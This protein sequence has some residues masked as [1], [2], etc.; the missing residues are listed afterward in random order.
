MAK[1]SNKELLT[2]AQNEETTPEQLNKIWVES[3][4]VKV[5]KAV[6][7][8]PNADAITLRYAARL[9]IEEVL[10]NPGFQVLKLFDDDEWIRKIGEIYDNPE[11]W[12]TVYYYA[13]RTEQLEP[14][15]RAALLSSSL[16]YV[17]LN[18]IIE[19][20]PV[21][22]LKRAFK[23]E[24]T[25]AK[26]RKLLKGEGGNFSL[27]AMFK[28]YNS[29]L[30]AEDE[31]YECLKYISFVGSLSCRKSVYTKTIKLLFKS[32]DEQKYGADKAM[33]M[34]L[35]ASRSTCIRWIQYMFEH[36]HLKII[37]SALLT[38]KR[39][40]KKASSTSRT[41]IQMLG[42]MI[43][44][45]LWDPLNF[46]QRKNSFES[47]YKSMCKLGLDTHPWGDTKF[48]WGAIHITNEMC[49]ELLKEDIRV[50]AFFV[51]NKCLGTWFSVQ[52]SSSKFQLVEEVNDW[53]YK[54]GGF[55]NLLYNSVSLRK[56]VTIS[57]DVIIAR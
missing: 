55:E 8:N 17:Q 39:L 53:M 10:E 12:S 15:A 4:S 23:Y 44:G 13:R 5:R 51:R 25:R 37:A 18:S 50:K 16:D 41:T 1:I 33:A 57:D 43:T 20:L 49:D 30:I 3:K 52:K 40:G 2:I 35:I 32:L 27:E 6:A 22:S 54:R 7:S 42:S 24:K 21:T 9:Y 28:A 29:E 36:K 14:F 45:V 56:I 34:I 31:L 26:I 19:F 46:D 48:T 11:S 38:A 47:I